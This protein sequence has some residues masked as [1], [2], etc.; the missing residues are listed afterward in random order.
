M[1]REF[2]RS[3]AVKSAP[4]SPLIKPNSCQSHESYY[5]KQKRIL[6]TKLPR[7]HIL[8]Q[9]SLAFQTLPD[10]VAMKKVNITNSKHLRAIKNLV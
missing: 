7:P 9:T 2:E 6:N 5:S 4:P 10:V 3:V 8:R 1:S